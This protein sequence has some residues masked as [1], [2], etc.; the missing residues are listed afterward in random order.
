MPSNSPLA[1]PAVYMRGGTSKGVFFHGKDLP[2]D[3]AERDEMLLRIMGSPDPYGRQMDGMGAATSSTS[4]VV[5]ITPSTRP[6][7]DVDYLFGQ[8][9]IDAPL[10]DW[11]GNCGNLSTA[12]G[13]FALANGLVSGPRDGIATVRIWQANIEKTIIAHVPMADGE[14][15]EDGDFILDGVAFAA[16][17]VELEFLDPAGGAGTVLLPTGNASDLLDLGEYGTVEATLINAGNPTVIVSAAALGLT[18][19][20]SAATVDAQKALLARCE[21]VRAAG[22]VRMGLAATVAEAT[23]FRPATPKLAYVSP[24]ASYITSDGREIAQDDVDLVVRMLSM[25][26]QHHAL[27][28][29][30]SIAI[31]V[32]TAIPGTLAHAQ[33]APRAGV[34]A[35]VRLGHGSG[36][37]AVGVKLD[38]DSAGRQQVTSVIISR[39]ARVLMEGRVRLPGKKTPK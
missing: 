27:T 16:A 19:T 28:G 30:G 23:Q 2:A 11:S 15:L 5:V 9:S 25:G 38:D 12:V 13:P 18:G 1:I 24:P 4:K 35:G 3:A 14:V 39:S 7:H 21:A 6:G 36:T 34:D 22:T 31:A 10:I 33:M 8:V 29:T 32:A 26:K 17:R 20:E 37:I